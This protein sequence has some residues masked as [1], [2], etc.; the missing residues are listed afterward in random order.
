MGFFSR[1]VRTLGVGVL[2]RFS[3]P[4]APIDVVSMSP[5]HIVLEVCGLTVDFN[6]VRALDDVSIALS[7]GEILGLIG[8][9]GAGKTTLI[10]AISG[11]QPFTRGSLVLA[12]VDVTRESP[13]RRARMGL[14]RTFQNVRVFSRLDVLENI[15]LAALATGLDRQSAQRHAREVIEQVGLTQ[16]IHSRAGSLPYGDLRRVGIGRAVAGRPRLLLLDEPAAGSNEQE[17]DELLAVI[18]GVRDTLQCG[19]L[20][21]E[22]DMPLVMRL[23]DR[24]QVLNYGRT[25]YIGSP[26]DVRSDPAVID[27]YLGARRGSERC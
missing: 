8:P 17:S 24:I 15:E 22:H 16:V 25:I 20:L 26:N 14:A 10:N 2:D 1:S 11:F 19:I 13:H 9:N 5:T 6:G 7:S 21:V 27:A 12:G 23:C 18:A 3:S 4:V